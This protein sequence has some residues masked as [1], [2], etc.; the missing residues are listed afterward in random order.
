[1]LNASDIINW[2]PSE[3]ILNQL[4]K[5]YSYIFPFLTKKNCVKVYLFTSYENQKQKKKLTEWK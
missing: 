3:K 4:L 5:V 2:N 1:M